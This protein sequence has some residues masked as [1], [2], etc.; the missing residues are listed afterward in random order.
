MILREE[1]DT[2][3]SDNDGRVYVYVFERKFFGIIVAY[4]CKFEKCGVNTLTFNC[5]IFDSS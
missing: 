4:K 5:C 2:S 3:G 1:E